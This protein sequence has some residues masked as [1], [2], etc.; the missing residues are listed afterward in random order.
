MFFA[1][2]GAIFLGG[3]GSCIIGGLY[4]KRGT[5]SG[6]WVALITG[7]VMAIGGMILRQTWASTLYPWMENSAPSILNGLTFMIEGISNAVPGINWRVEPK[8]FPINSQWIYFF[9]IIMALGGYITCSVF[10][11]LVSK[12]PAFNMDKLLHRGKYAIQGE[13]EKEVKKPPTGIKAILPSAEFTKSD[14]FIYYAKMVWSLIWFAIFVV[15]SSYNL[16][17]DVP[18]STWATFWGWKVGITLVIGIITTI[19]FFVGGVYDLRDMMITLKKVKRNVLD[20]GMVVNHHN[21]G[22]QAVDKK[23]FKHE[24]EEFEQELEEDGQ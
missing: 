22:E 14:K 16:A 23:E 1:I 4:W 5:T 24:V 15:V 6:A 21:L 3:V 12:R 17:V 2:T 18:D 13:H 11:W 20:D 19:W 7:C 8:A 10:E 9:S